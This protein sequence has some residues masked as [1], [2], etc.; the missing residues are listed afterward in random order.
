MGEL[1]LRS[2][3]LEAE[4][5]THAEP[6]LRYEI[7]TPMYEADNEFANF[8]LATQKLVT[9]KDGSIEERALRSMDWNN[10]A[11][12]ASVWPIN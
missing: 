4:Q 3:R 11:P 6:R 9:A 7:T 1:V 5:Q 8:D 12:R 2:G 10:F